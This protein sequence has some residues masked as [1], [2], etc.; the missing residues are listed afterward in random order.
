[1]DEQ[2]AMGWYKPDGTLA[3][4]FKS[5]EAGAA[6]SIWCAVSPLLDGQGGVYCEDCNIAAVFEEGMN[7]YS[8]ARLHILDR[9]DA[10]ALWVASETMTGVPFER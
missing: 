3:D 10:A 6:T 7:P 4:I 9:D 8:G 1:M 2:V 5:T